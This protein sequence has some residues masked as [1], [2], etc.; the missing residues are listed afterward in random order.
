MVC[1]VWKIV[2]WG[3]F[4]AGSADERSVTFPISFATAAYYGQH[5][6]VKTGSYSYTGRVTSLSRTAIGLSYGVW[7]DYGGD[8]KHIWFCL[9]K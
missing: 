1:N 6:L 5:E 2:Q 3:T 4:N 8:V 9:G 7:G